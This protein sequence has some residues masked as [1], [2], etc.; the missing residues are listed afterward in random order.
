MPVKS[1]QRQKLGGRNWLISTLDFSSFLTKSKYYDDSNK[2]VIGKMEDE[3]GGVAV[4]ELVRVKPKLYSVLIDDSSEHKKAKGVNINVVATIR[5]N[6][7]KHVLSNYKCLRHS[8]NRIQS[9]DHRIGTNDIKKISLCCFDDKIY[10]HIY[11]W[12]I[13]SWLSELIR[14]KAVISITN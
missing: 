10:F 11:I 9:K 3:T 13:S 8:V 7:Y 6:E 4:E 2:L 14:Q 12:W 5:H 1:K